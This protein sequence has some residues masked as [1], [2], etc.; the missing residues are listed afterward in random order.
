MCLYFQ[1]LNLLLFFTAAAAA[2][3][4][5]GLDFRTFFHTARY[6]F[7]HKNIGISI[8]SLET[9]MIWKFFHLSCPQDKREPK[10][11]RGEI[12]ILFYFLFFILLFIVDS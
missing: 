12:F 6:R 2:A 1:L 10:A 8:I 9:E 5:H 11:G 7:Y 4:H 3:S